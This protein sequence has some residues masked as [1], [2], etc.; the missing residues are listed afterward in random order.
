M[1]EWLESVGVGVPGY[2]TPKVAIGADRRQRRRRAAARP[3]GRLGD[4]AVPDRVGR[5]RLLAGRG[6]RQ[7]GRRG[8]RHRVRAA[9]GVL[10]VIDGQRMGFSRFGMYMLLFHCHGDRRRAAAPPAGVRRRRLVRPRRPAGDDRRRP[11]V[12]AD[13]VRRDRRRGVP[14]RLRRRPLADLARRASR[15]SPIAPRVVDRADR[16]DRPLGVGRRVAVAQE[17]LDLGDELVGVDVGVE[18]SSVGVVVARSS[19]SSSSSSTQRLEPGDVL[20]EVVV[21]GDQGGDA[22]VVLGG[23]AGEARRRAP[24]CRSAGTPARRA[25]AP[26][27]ATAPGRRTAGTAAHSDAVG[28]AGRASARRGARRRCRSGPRSASAAARSGRSARGRWPCR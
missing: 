28:D 17:A 23:A 9:R 21:V 10:A 4:L 8:D 19:S 13:G 20:D 18:R 24:G 12:G 14:D 22:G 27:S 11:V 26:P 16:S 6:R 3:A 5:R 15:L 1:Q 2:V 7:G 25:P